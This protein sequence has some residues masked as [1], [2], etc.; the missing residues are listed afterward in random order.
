VL[1]ER[2]W[3]CQVFLK[4]DNYFVNDYTFEVIYFTDLSPNVTLPLA[5]A[6]CSLAQ[7]LSYD[8]ELRGGLRGV[9]TSY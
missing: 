7:V 8:A 3:T 2:R 5:A 9:T 4:C 6:L 1:W